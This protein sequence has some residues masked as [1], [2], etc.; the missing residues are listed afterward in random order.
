ME[1]LA[2]RCSMKR[3]MVTGNDL[4]TK[5]NDLHSLR[6]K[7]DKLESVT[8]DDCLNQT[9]KNAARHSD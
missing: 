2:L 5:V 8:D 6:L 1:E 9:G 7:L 3:T 4:F